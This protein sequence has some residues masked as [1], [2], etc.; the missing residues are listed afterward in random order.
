M[1]YY[2]KEDEIQNFLI[3]PSTFDW[4][5]IDQEL[6]FKKI[7]T[8][9]PKSKYLAAKD[10]H[11]E[12]FRLLTK[13]AVHYGFV[14]SIP[15]IKVQITNYGINNLEQQKSKNANWWD[16]R[17]LGLSLIKIADAC[18]SEAITLS[19]GT[20]DLDFF[21]NSSIIVTPFDFENIYSINN[22]I[23]TFMQLKPLINKAKSINIDSKIGKDCFSA[24][25]E[26]EDI[27][28]L[29][30]D[31]LVFYA[32]YYSAKLPNFT[33]T[34]NSVIVQY[35]E[36][37]WQ[38]SQVLDFNAKMITAENFKKLADE[39]MKIII[40]YLKNNPEEFPCYPEPGG[41]FLMQSRNSG[42]YL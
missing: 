2:I 21:Q 26:N 32:L 38:K 10:S 13:A 22:S 35:E 12:I 15:K 31:A 41:E 17:D 39:T 34:Q 5:L 11:Q 33:F 9:F 6:G 1:D 19:K 36:L 30:K 40:D 18:F 23:D 4:E 37:P 3:L 28:P 16:V 25:K 8:I 42:I 7:F 14:F 24:V 20:I 29:L 27:L